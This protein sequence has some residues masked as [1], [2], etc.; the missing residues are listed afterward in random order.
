MEMEINILYLG[1]FRYNK[2]PKSQNFPEFSTTVD[3]NVIFR[4]YLEYIGIYENILCC[5][6]EL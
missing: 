5:V 6:A 3:L 4:G 2:L 1:L